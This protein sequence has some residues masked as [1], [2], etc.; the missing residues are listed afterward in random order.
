MSFKPKP[1]RSKTWFV[2][3]SRHHVRACIVRCLRREAQAAACLM[4]GEPMTAFW[5]NEL[6]TSQRIESIYFPKLS[7]VQCAALLGGVEFPVD[8]EAREEHSQAKRE[9]K[10]A[11]AAG[12]A[13]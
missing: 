12:G 8:R 1:W 3:D 4:F 7:Q 13:R 10:H 2:V 9:R 5:R 6:T 11:V